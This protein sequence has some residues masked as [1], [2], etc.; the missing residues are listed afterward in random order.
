[1]DKQNN[2]GGMKQCP[3]C[4]KQL[5]ASVL[6]CGNCFYRFNDEKSAELYFN[7][8]TKTEK[9]TIPLPQTNELSNK[10]TP[11]FPDFNKEDIETNTDTI[12]NEKNLSE[13][14]LDDADKKGI[15]VKVLIAVAILLA[16]ISG[17]IF[18]P[19]SNNSD[20]NVEIS[21]NIA[22]VDTVAVESVI[23]EEEDVIYDCISDCDGIYTDETGTFDEIK[24][25]YRN[26][27]IKAVVEMY[28]MASFSGYA[29]YE[30]GVLQ[31]GGK[32]DEI[33]MTLTHESEGKLT[34]TY[35]LTYYDKEGKIT[36]T[37]KNESTPTKQYQK[38]ENYTFNVAYP[39]TCLADRWNYEIPGNYIISIDKQ[40]RIV[41][42]DFYSND[43]SKFSKK[44]KY[45]EVS[46]NVSDG[47]SRLSSGR[48]RWQ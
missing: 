22:S 31:I 6:L 48:C 44:I 38:K 1:M 24:L 37:R 7:P 25:F 12:E 28:R 29:K 42:F 32:D 33:Q 36:I 39:Y 15:V 23:A 46:G 30:N 21:D 19:S 11:T 35:K 40:R 43:K 27:R 10:E 14:I 13:E 17:I 16:V 2:N 26:G 5:N 47:D 18:W 41:S 4:G 3:R 20:N 8:G 45:S 34:G 9:K